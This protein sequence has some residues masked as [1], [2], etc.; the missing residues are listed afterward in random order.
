MKQALLVIGAVLAVLCYPLLFPYTPDSGPIAEPQNPLPA[1]VVDA[2]PEKAGCKP[3]A[4]KPAAG[5][6]A[7]PCP[8]TA[9][10][11]GGA[12]LTAQHLP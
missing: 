12:P 9:Q 4:G 10:I 3:R 8:D 6:P 11:T 7:G 2:A 1:E 5:A